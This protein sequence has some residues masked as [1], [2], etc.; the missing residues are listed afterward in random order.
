MKRSAL[1]LV[2]LLV[3]TFGLTVRADAAGG[4][5]C[6]DTIMRSTKLRHNLNCSVSPALTIGA[7]NITLNLDHHTLAG[8]PISIGIF[9]DGKDHVTVKGGTVRNFGT[10]IKFMNGNADHALRVTIVNDATGITLD[11]T[12]NALVSKNKLSRVQQGI[13]DISGTMDDVIV[14]NRISSINFGIALT[15]PATRTVVAGN[16][17]SSG[18]IDDIATGNSFDRI[19]RNTITGAATGIVVGAFT[20][21]QQIDTNRLVRST[22]DGINI[23]NGA[24]E[25][26]VFGNRAIG[27]G[28][29]GIDDASTALGIHIGDNDAVRNG[30][31]GIEAQPETDDA[32]GNRA[33]R[34]GHVTHAV[35]QC[36]EVVCR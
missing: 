36:V 11:G 31:F 14:S 15:G 23:T 29:D 20:A 9:A 3:S 4:P 2:V 7:D 16:H 35:F 12:S 26:T 19:T 18:G 27:N 22:Q 1:L 10:G 30:N 8:L 24:A 21:N 34:N 28:N 5:N 6:G 17:L 33:K 25:L 32:G 13:A